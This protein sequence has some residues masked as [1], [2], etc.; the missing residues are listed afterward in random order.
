MGVTLG[1]YDHDGRLD[2]FI[3]NFDDD[4]NVLYHNDG[5][6]S[7]TDVSY[8]AKLAAVSLPYVGWGTWFFDYDNDGWADLLVV[9]GHVYP[10]LPTY[11]QRNFVHHNNRDGTFTE[12]GAQLGEAFAEKRTGRGAAFGDIDNDGDTDVVINNLD[13]PPQVLRNDGGNA[14]NSIS[15]KTIGVKSNRDGI[16]AR[17]KIVSGDVTEM[18]EVYSGG[19]Y[20]SQSDLRLSFGLEKRTKVDLIEVRWPSGA[21]DRITGAGVNRVITIKEGQGIV[22]Q[23]DFKKDAGR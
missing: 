23:K 16:G 18:A 7:F 12:V 22:A 11:R 21:V 9:N 2:L 3:T 15:I 13:G 19:S 14:N 1:D 5:K 10:Q 20:L 4:Y 17:V 8:A 6:G